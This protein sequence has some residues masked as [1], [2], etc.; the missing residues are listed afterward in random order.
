MESKI[1]KV[2]P[3]WIIMT[4]EEG[5]DEFFAPR[6]YR[7][8][9]VREEPPGEVESLIYS[10]GVSKIRYEPKTRGVLGTLTLFATDESTIDEGEKILRE[11][12]YID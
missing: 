7:R 10:T 12:G 9:I 3:H 8:Y 11:R 1:F 2:E 6:Y 5:W 4:T